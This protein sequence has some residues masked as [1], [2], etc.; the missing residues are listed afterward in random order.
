MSV[1][2][3]SLDRNQLCEARDYLRNDILPNVYNKVIVGNPLEATDYYRE[4]RPSLMIRVSYRC[5]G[6]HGKSYQAAEEDQ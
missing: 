5:N 6:D 4:E 2:L 1:R 3:D